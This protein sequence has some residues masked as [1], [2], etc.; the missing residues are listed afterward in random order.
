MS[1]VPLEN[2]PHI[3]AAL[4]KLLLNPFEYLN[5]NAFVHDK[6]ME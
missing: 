2:L 5:V 3:L 1:P 6:K 4:E